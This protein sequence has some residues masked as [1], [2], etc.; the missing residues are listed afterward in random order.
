[1]VLPARA[2]SPEGGPR[3]RR[4][5]LRRLCVGLLRRIRRHM[6]GAAR[7]PGRALAGPALTLVPLLVVAIG[8]G[9]MGL[10]WL[11]RA[12]TA[13]GD[14]PVTIAVEPRDAT[15]E[16]AGVH[17]TG[18]PFTTRLRPGRYRVLIRRPGHKSWLSTLE[19]A[20]GEHQTLHVALQPGD[21]SAAKLS[22]HSTPP[23]L[24]LTIDGR[25]IATPTPLD[26]DLPPGPH[27][28]V[29][30]AG[31][32]ELWRHRYV[33]RRDTHHA[34][35][36]V[37]TGADR[38]AASPVPRRSSDRSLR[39]PAASVP[40]PVEP[41]PVSPGPHPAVPAPTRDTRTPPG[42]SADTPAATTPEAV[43]PARAPAAPAPVTAPPPAT[44]PGTR[45]S[46]AA[47]LTAASSPETVS[48][49]ELV[50]THGTLPRRTDHMPPGT[51]RARLCMD[52]SGTVT[53][54]DLLSE[55]PEEAET[56]LET[57]LLGWRYEPY[58]ERGTAIP[59]CFTE[60]LQLAE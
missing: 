19:L 51:V 34:F 38:S 7:R 41:L 29:L 56:Q 45:A 32:R 28:L 4:R 25:K 3:P 58:L 54:A 26:L 49:S 11:S 22:V 44:T 43:A 59:V 1:V 8:G 39:P 35:Y 24:F 12:T 36:P 31:T 47:P 60:E 53:S 42:S 27:E 18:S 37:L 23:G 13:S 55:L 16:L 17:Y 21:S 40:A 57:A 48:S 9:I 6:Q 14:V 2:A 5:R 20:R 50:R 46:S 10:R 52:R 30:H 33:A 15:I